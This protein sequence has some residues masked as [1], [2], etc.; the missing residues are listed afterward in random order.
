MPFRIPSYQLKCFENSRFIIIRFITRK[1]LELASLTKPYIDALGRF[2]LKLSWQCRKVNYL[3][4]HK[5][6][7]I[8]VIFYYMKG[9]GET[10]PTL[11]NYNLGSF[12]AAE[13]WQN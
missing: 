5:E 1:F 3:N 9:N 7:F 13:K 12:T 10:L 2:L 4:H 8:T 6:N 11:T